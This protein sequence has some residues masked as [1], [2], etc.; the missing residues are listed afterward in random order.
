MKD[1]ILQKKCGTFKWKEYMTR[2]EIQTKTALLN[3]YS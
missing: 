3:A 2:K 1:W